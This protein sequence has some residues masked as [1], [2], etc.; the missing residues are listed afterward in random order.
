VLSDTHLGVAPRHVE[1]A[2]IDFLHAL[3]GQAGSLV[4]NGDLFDFWFEWRSV[5]PRHGFRVL[6]ALADLRETGVPILWLAGNHDGWGGSVLRE[7]VGVEYHM[8]VWQGQLGGWNARVEHGDGL[9]PKADRGYRALRRVIRH[10]LSI[11]LFRWLHPDWG[12]RLAMGSSSVSRAH[13]HAR[14]GHAN[15]SSELR[16]IGL[17]TLARHRELELLIYGHSHQAA[18]ERAPGGAV[19]ANAGS[20]LDAPT[21][22]I[23]TRD[24]IELCRWNGSAEGECLDSL[25]RRT[26]LAQKALP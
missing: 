23:V 5:I 20:W 2:V 9:R 13:T 11:R 22:L 10:P 19:Y 21:Y 16:D 24:R 8:G 3:Q 12:T 25:D 14:G 7:D 1:M 4:I 17:R 6:A 15:E 18:L 26:Q